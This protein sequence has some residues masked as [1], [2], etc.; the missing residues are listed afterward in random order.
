MTK[1]VLMIIAEG[2]ETIEIV[3]PYDSLKYAGIDVTLASV[4]NNLPVSTSCNL[5]IIPDCSLIDVKNENFDAI[6]LPGGLIGTEK[7][8]NVNFIIEIHFFRIIA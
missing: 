1:K 6:I 7:L 8:R 2:S 5:K 3:I 4:E